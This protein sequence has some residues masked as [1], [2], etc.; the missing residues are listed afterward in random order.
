MMGIADDYYTDI[1]PDPTDEQLESIRRT[2][3]SLCGRTEP[4]DPEVI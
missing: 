1:A 4:K 3:R 2:L